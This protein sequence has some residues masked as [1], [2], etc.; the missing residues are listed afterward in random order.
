MQDSCPA[1][2][3]LA[4]LA[5]EEWAGV[6]RIIKRL[7][8]VGKIHNTEQ[9]KKIRGTDFWE[10]K[11]FQIR[12]FSYFDSQRQLVITHGCKK[13]QQKLDRA[14]IDRMQRIRAWCERED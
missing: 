12:V 3:F 11:S 4:G 7:A 10:F 8:D 6:V 14:E 5:K 1:E 13:K 9:F 2:E